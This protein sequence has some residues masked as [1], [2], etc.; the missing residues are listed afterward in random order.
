M[1]ISYAAFTG[2]TA[3]TNASE[4]YSWL[5]DNANDYIENL[6]NT[7]NVITFDIIGGG[8]VKLSPTITTSS[9]TNNVLTL[10]NAVTQ[11]LN[12]TGGA[13]FTGAY[14]TS[15]AIMLII[16]NTGFIAIFKSNNNTIG[17]IA[18]PSTSTSSMY[19][20]DLIDSANFAECK[21][22]SS[23]SITYNASLT[24]LSNIPLSDSGNY[25]IGVYLPIFYQYDTIGILS[26]NNI[27]YVYN[28]HIA[29]AE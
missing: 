10:K 15:K 14:K 20:A 22:S 24:A 27:N 3:E 4:I 16:A 19:I 26:H 13:K 6:L 18:K 2:Q 12:L 7:D 8:S 25:A 5:T 9:S 17:I 21:V 23:T 29:I 1:S 28:K 11:S